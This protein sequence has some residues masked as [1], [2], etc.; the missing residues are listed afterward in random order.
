MRHL[1]EAKLME[2]M[3]QEVH[4]CKNNEGGDPSKQLI[5]IKPV[6]HYTMGGIDV[7]SNFEVNGLKRC[8]GV[9]ECSNAK[10]HGA[11]RLGGNSLLEIVAFGK[12]VGEMV[13]Q[14]SLSD[15]VRTDSK[16]FKER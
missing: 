4:L 9:G 7:N 8:Y 15:E 14:S 5:P 13:S 6:A 3:P 10:V 11:N 2:L 12:L 16:Q 1:G